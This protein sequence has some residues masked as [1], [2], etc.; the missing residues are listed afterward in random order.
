MASKSN[1][2]YLEWNTISYYAHESN[3]WHIICQDTAEY[4]RVNVGRQKKNGGQ[5]EDVA[6]LPI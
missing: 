2:A 3:D 6:F 4:E 1:I 5:K